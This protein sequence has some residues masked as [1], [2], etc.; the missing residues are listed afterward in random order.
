MKSTRCAIVS[1]T[2]ILLLAP[3][4]YG[5]DLSRYR[6]FSF[7]T[8]LAAISKQIDRRLIDAEVI[9]QKPGLIQEL[10]WYPPITF[11][12]LQPDEPVDKILFSFYNGSLYRML[13]VYESSAVKGLT[14]DDMIRVVSAQFGTADRSG[15]NLNFPTNPPYTANEKV[16]GRWEDRQYS[17]NLIRYSASDT[18]AL[19]I[20]DKQLDAQAGVSIAKSVQLE[21]QGAPQKE[22]DRVKKQADDL[23]IERQNDI[24]MF[25][26]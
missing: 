6:S 14:N 15:A 25:R 11:Y 16:I 20:F 10:S 22:A 13:V 9:Y 8:S 12:S 2:T 24:K 3:A 21:R 19:V 1:L 18:F 23:E 4:L 5:Q 26:P 7:G 17:L